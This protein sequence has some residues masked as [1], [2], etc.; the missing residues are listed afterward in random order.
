MTPTL[1]R[2][3]RWALAATVALLL[4]PA[5]LLAQSAKARYETAQAREQRVRQLIESTSPG[6][7]EANRERVFRET[8]TVVNLY[9]AIARRYPTS[10]YSDNALFQAAS[11]YEALWDRYARATDRGEAISYYRRVI[12][13]YPSSSLVK[14]SRRNIAGL[15]AAARAAEARQRA[16]AE[17]AQAAE[18]A[19]QEA[20]QR[21]VPA[22]FPTPARRDPAPEPPATR[23]ADDIPHSTTPVPPPPVVEGGDGPSSDAAPA[24]TLVNIER[25]VLPETVRITVELDHE[26]AYHQEQIDD[27]SRVFFDLQGVQ[28]TPAL[29]DASLSYPDDVVREIRVGRHP[30]QTVRV[31]LDIE[32]VTRYSVF[33]LYN[34]F[35]LVVDAERPAAMNTTLRTAVD[36]AAPVD[37]IPAAAAVAAE[38][39]APPAPPTANSQGGFSLSRQLGL[40]VSRIVIDPGHGGKDPG[41]QI[42]G[43]NEA[44]LVLDVALRLEKLLKDEPGVEVVLTRRTNV[45][46]PLEERTAIANREQADLFL[47][48]HVNASRNRAAGGVETY[49]LS[50]ASSPEAEEVAARENSASGREMHNL[51]DIIKAIALNNKLDESHDLAQMVQESL[52]AKLKPSNRALSNRGVK[53]APFVV[54]IGAAMPSVLAEIAFITNRQEAQLLKTAAYKQR[55]AES[56]HQAVLKYRNSLKRQTTV[57]EKP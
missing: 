26:V 53:K 47:S 37:A 21:P 32:D 3:A 2:S 14:T 57:A 36:R 45:F 38:P 41:T 33:T 5:P 39:A 20:R 1:L 51:P 50:F 11:L 28:V 55:I 16:A 18:R 46:I 19:R 15:E 56:L 22:P 43:L 34:P 10:G 40:G 54:L 52:V 24:A 13:E 9:H 25:V 29:L 17:A 4:V 44:D 8:R 35:R 7:S 23:A 12:A 27:P 42:K 6:A 49:F 48:I 30:D 31:V